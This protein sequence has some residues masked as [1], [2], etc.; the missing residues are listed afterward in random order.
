MKEKRN[1][2]WLRKLVLIALCLTLTVISV[3]CPAQAADSDSKL[4]VTFLDVGQADA[5]LI[6]CDGHSMLIDGGNAADSSKMYTVMKNH[7][8]TELD[9]VIGTHAHEDHIGGLAGAL[10]YASVKTAYSPVTTYDSKAFQNFRKAVEK[11]GVSLTVPQKD[12]TF[13]LGSAECKILAVNSDSDTNNTS[14]VLRITLGDTSFLFTGDAEREVEQSS[15]Q[16]IA[17]S[18]IETPHPTEAHFDTDHTD[19]GMPHSLFLFVH[20]SLFYLFLLLLYFFVGAFP[21]QVFPAQAYPV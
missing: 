17:L 8:I 7:K 1:K 20:L 10:N 18:E 13:S 11:H 14:I 15:P 19:G 21:P 12:D 6:Q 16:G 5:A 9:Y 2:T 4:E 3:P